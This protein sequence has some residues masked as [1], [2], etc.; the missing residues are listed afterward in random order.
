M[1]RLAAAAM[2][3]CPTLRCCSCDQKARKDHKRVAEV[4]PTA[5]R[6]VLQASGWQPKAEHDSAEARSPECDL[7]DGASPS[8]RQTR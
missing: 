2:L 4:A 3:S 5:Y 6:Y 1:D 8:S 7:R